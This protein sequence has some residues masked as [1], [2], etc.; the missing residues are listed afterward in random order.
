[1]L[2]GQLSTVTW[3]GHNLPWCVVWC[4]VVWKPC[5]AGF[6]LGACES[7]R[8]SLALCTLTCRGL[9]LTLTCSTVSCRVGASSVID[10]QYSLYIR[11]Y[12]V[13]LYVCMY[14]RMYVSRD[15]SCWKWTLTLKWDHMQSRDAT[16]TESSPNS[17]SNDRILW[18][19]VSYPCTYIRLH[20]HTYMFSRASYV[21]SCTDNV[22]QATLW[23]T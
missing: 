15:S 11:I 4:G 22:N 14:V 18:L 9:G 3:S 2:T 7:G 1:M 13:C 5:S 17:F 10:Y 8:A 19:P 16:C 6:C 23:M 12:A 20:T 21:Y